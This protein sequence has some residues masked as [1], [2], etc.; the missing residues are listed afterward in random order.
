MIALLTAL[1][2]LWAVPMITAIDRALVFNGWRNFRDVI[3]G[4]IGGVTL[5]RT[6]LNSGLVAIMHAVLVVTVSTLA[7]YAFSFFSFKGK[8]AVYFVVLISWRFRRP[9]YW[10]RCSSSC[11]SCTSAT[12]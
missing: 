1:A 10:C 3:L 4:D 5:F 7:G 2:I 12:R 8:E 9:R 6:Y 11:A